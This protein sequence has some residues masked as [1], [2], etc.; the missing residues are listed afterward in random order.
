V[1]LSLVPNKGLVLPFVS[2]GASAMM[3]NLAA[4]G[5]LLSVSAE[6]RAAVIVR[7]ETRVPVPA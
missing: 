1:V 5:V 3:V 6:A 4:V 7:P 2:Y